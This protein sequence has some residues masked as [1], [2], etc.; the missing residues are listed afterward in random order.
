MKSRT[1]SSQSVFPTGTSDAITHYTPDLKRKQQWLGQVLNFSVSSL[2]TQALQ[3]YC[4]ERKS[5][6]GVQG[7]PFPCG[8]CTP[9]RKWEV[10]FQ[11]SGIWSDGEQVPSSRG[12]REEK[13]FGSLR[14]MSFPW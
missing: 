5:E 4:W 10:E 9:S 8:I 3:V 1:G 14:Q 11:T 13:A 6:M 2:D 7:P 12:A